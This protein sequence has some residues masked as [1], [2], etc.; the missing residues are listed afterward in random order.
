M[1][2]FFPTEESI[3]ARHLML[4]HLKQYFKIGVIIIRYKTIY[5]LP[6]RN[7][8]LKSFSASRTFFHL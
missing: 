7:H 6:I 1:K 8:A 5:D 3:K 4:L 2:Y